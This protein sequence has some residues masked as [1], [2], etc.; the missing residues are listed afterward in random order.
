[1]DNDIYTESEGLKGYI[2]EKTSSIAFDF[3]TK[4]PDSLLCPVKNPE[5]KV[6]KLI[7]KATKKSALYSA[8]LSL[9]G[10]PIGVFTIIPDL[11]AIWRIQAQL[12]ADIAAT[13]GQIAVLNRETMIWCLFRHSAAQIVRDLS[14]RTGTRILTHRISSPIIFSLIKKIGLRHSS[15][16]TQRALLRFIPILG[17]IG[18][19]TYAYF[20]TLGVGKT[21]NAYFKALNDH[22]P[23]EDSIQNTD[24]IDGFELN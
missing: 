10:G 2:Q 11:T 12:V 4:I 14:V 17:S 18:S 16:L 23:I 20:D 8:T 21:A 6:K 9:P 3:I 19:G 1:M 13:Y 7:Q 5:K 22:S 24:S 15:K